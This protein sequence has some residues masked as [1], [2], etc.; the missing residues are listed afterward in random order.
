[1]DHHEIEKSLFVER[2]VV[3]D[4]SGLLDLKTPVKVYQFIAVRV[5]IIFVCVSSP[6]SLTLRRS[7]PPDLQNKNRLLQDGMMLR[8]LHDFPNSYK[9][10]HF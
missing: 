8:L 6:H 7:F 4:T 2:G 1:M 5:H 3:S 9:N 10:L